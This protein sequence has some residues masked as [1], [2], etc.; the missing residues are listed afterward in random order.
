MTEGRAARVL[1]VA[2]QTADS[3][4]LLTAVAKRAAAGPCSFTLLVPATPPA[5]TR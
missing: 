5:L 2:H 3:P 4:E 1:I